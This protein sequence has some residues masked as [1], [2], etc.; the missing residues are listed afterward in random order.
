MA[1]ECLCTGTTKP[2]RAD[3]LLY[4]KHKTVELLFCRYSSISTKTDNQKYISLRY[5]SCRNLKTLRR[6]T[7]R[8]CCP[9]K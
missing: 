7:R 9:T 6:S 1:L 4:I 3:I 2:R 8:N 5:I